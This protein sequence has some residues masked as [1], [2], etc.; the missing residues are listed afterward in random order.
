MRI[1]HVLETLSPRYGGPAVLLP[2]LAK[3]QTTAGHEVVIATT[4]ADHPRGI[5]H[6]PG[7]DT[8]ADGTVKVFYASVDFAPLLVT[9]SL[10][11]YLR[12][13]IAEFD[14]VN[15]HGLYRFPTTYAASLA[16]RRGVPYV[17]IP[18][19]SLDPYLYEK[20]TTGKLRLKRL[21][22]RMFT[23]P[24]LQAANAI[25]YTA[26]EERERVAFL[27]LQAPSFVV[28][29]GLDW[30]PYRVL[31]P[32]GALRSRWGLGEAPVVLFLGRL[33]VKKGLDLLIPAFDKVR[34]NEPDA[35]LVIAGP[36]N[37]DYGKS[38][39]GWVT[40]RGLDSITHF[41]GTLHGP[42]V[43]QAYVD[44]DVFALPSYTENFGV[45]VAEAMA[46]ACPVVISDQVNIHAAIS[47][48]GAGLVTRCDIEETAEALQ[49]LL[50]DAGRRVDMGRAGRQLVQERYV[51]PAIVDAL[52][53]EY[54]AA[55]ERSHT[56]S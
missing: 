54:E 39:R 36:E 41:V 21:Y 37:D 19:G 33:H 32:R 53:K 4:T 44:A 3:A 40:E 16:R 2:Q 38:V 17:V 25:H 27:N 34:R 5:Y 42:D 49:T 8:L 46:C 50:R 35:Q 22:E 20:S 14:L 43:R 18:H 6:E 7:W 52:T 11:T 48:A 55:I 31:P 15:V 47:S 9:R 51:W 45:A 24:N 13:N 26:E 10:A 12:R 28:P 1:L 30:E 29:N 23:M 56:N